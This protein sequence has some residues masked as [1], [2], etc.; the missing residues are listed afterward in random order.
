MSEAAKAFV[1]KLSESES[2][3]GFS[4]FH[5]VSGAAPVYV[6][7]CTGIN[8]LTLL[9]RAVVAVSCATYQSCF[10]VLW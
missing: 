7:Q 10:P 5:C 2:T 6:F 3:C 8:Q 4:E 9:L 1:L